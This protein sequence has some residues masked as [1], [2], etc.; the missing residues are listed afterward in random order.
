MH[1]LLLGIRARDVNHSAACDITRP[2]GRERLQLGEESAMSSLLARRCWLAALAA[3]LFAAPAKA[4]NA[5]DTPEIAKAKYLWSKS[6]HGKMLERILP[7]AITPQDLPDPSSEGA[8]LAARYCVQC[9]YLPNP[10][11]HSGDR[12]KPVVARMVWRMQGRGNMGE[13]MREMMAD[14]RAPTNGEVTV[15]AEYLQKHAQQEIAPE[16]PAL[17]STAGKMFA[18]ACSQC[19]A[20]PDP[21]Q[22]TAREWP[23]VVQRMRRH[24]QWAN[25]VV[26]SPELRTVPELKTEEI[27]ALL[28]RY[29]RP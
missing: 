10:R 20:L 27:V 8:Q 12:W 21:G 14:V 9:H 28:Q 24:M 29:A 5:V 15:L 11:M 3:V 16:H 2:N 19:H 13:L 1:A 25:L 4:Q 17:K 23:A 26:G 22:H 18:I 7:P 6:P